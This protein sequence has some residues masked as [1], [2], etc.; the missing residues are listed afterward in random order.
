MPYETLLLDRDTPVAVVTLNRP[1]A[2]NALNRQLIAELDDVL[3]RVQADAAIRALV[4]T[5][6]GDRAFAAGADIS[7]LAALGPDAARAFAT[8]GQAVFARLESLGKPSVAAVNGFALGGG[9]ELAMACTLRV[10]AESAQFGQP[11]IDLG[12]LPG[13]GGTQRLTRLVGRGRALDLLLRGHRITATEAERIGLVNIVVPTA[14]L[15]ERARG[16]AGELASKAPLAVRYVL[17]A[18]HEGAD[19]PLDAAN[20]IEAAY[21]GLAAATGDM[22]EGTRA[23]LEKRKPAFEGR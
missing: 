14:S 10:A 23:F 21:F 17:A 3:A 9:C 16:L 1:K 4:V 8:T 20:R 22:R 6:A 15:M 5:G 7:E 18:V 11:E 2:L 13:F 12:L 19:L